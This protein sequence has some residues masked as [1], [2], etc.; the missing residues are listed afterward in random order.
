M[1]R[2]IM[3]NK[4]KKI[5]A[6]IMMIAIVMVI[7][8]CLCC[9]PKAKYTLLVLAEIASVFAEMLVF[10]AMLKRERSATRRC[11]LVAGKLESI[12]ATVFRQV[13]MNR[14][15][16]AMHEGRSRGELSAERLSTAIARELAKRGIGSIRMNFP[17]CG[18]EW[19]LFYEV[20]G[21]IKKIREL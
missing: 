8:L 6:I 3:M 5:F 10:R 12:F 14:F 18:N 15:E 9:V 13:A 16:A 17:G 20:Y 11:A 2:K 1:E 19:M 21:I 4:K 7:Y